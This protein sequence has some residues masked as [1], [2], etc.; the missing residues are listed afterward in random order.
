VD[1]TPC[2]A[3]ELSLQLKTIEGRFFYWTSI[4]TGLVERLED[5]GER[6]QIF[7]IDK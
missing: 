3:K 1:I 5:S 2:Q 7:I 4:G 6:G